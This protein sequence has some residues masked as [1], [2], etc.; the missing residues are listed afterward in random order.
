VEASDK[1]KLVTEQ[2]DKVQ[3]ELSDF[4]QTYELIKTELETTKANAVKMPQEKFTG[5][6]LNAL[7]RARVVFERLQKVQVPAVG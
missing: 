1:M 6:L 3:A 7:T 5:K 4:R 2:A